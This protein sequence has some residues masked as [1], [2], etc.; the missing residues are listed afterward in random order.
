MERAIFA[1]WIKAR[2]YVYRGVDILANHCCPRFDSRISHD[3][4][5]LFD[6]W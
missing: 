5:H 2:A 6:F 1:S 4:Y 3:L